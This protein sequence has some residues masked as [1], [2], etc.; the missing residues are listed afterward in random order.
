[1]QNFAIQLVKQEGPYEKTTA[2]EA[3]RNVVPVIS[4]KKGSFVNMGQPAA[5]EIPE[6]HPI[7]AK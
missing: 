2:V 6:I 5:N 7:L 3:D 4:N 1:V